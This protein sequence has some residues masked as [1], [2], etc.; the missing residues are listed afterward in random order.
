M[1]KKCSKQIWYESQKRCRSTFDF[2]AAGLWVSTSFVH[3]EMF[4]EMFEYSSSV[5]LMETIWDGSDDPFVFQLIQSSCILMW[6]NP[7]AQRYSCNQ[8]GAPL[9]CYILHS[10][11]A[12]LLWFKQSALQSQNHHDDSSGQNSVMSE[13]TVEPMFKKKANEKWT[14][15]FNQ[16]KWFYLLFCFS[17]L[18]DLL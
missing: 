16:Q 14:L 4:T 1:R 7:A 8:Q 6:R 3:L 17:F 12:D 2:P 15:T 13:I 18:A 9:L 11:T 10:Q 5:T